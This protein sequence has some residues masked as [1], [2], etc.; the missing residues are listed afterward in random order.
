M[1]NGL[2][3][4]ISC[5]LNDNRECI[6]YDVELDSNLKLMS[7]LGQTGVHCTSATPFADMKHLK[8][9]EREINW[10]QVYYCVL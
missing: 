6:I 1:I 4:M 9:D 2:A 8:C 10:K 3:I 7:T 5:I